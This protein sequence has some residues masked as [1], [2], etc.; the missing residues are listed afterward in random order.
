MRTDDYYSKSRIYLCITIC[1]T[2]YFVFLSM[3]CTEFLS[4]RKYTGDTFIRNYNTSFKSVFQVNNVN[5]VAE[6]TDSI[7][8]GSI[9]YNPEEAYLDWSSIEAE[10]ERIRLES[11]KLKDKLEEEK[12]KPT[13]PIHS[14][15]TVKV[16][17]SMDLPNISDTS[18][19]GYMCMH[20]V[21][22]TDSYQWK[23]LHSGDFK[24]HTDENGIMMYEDYYVV[25]M[26]SYYT[27]YKVGS[28][29]RITLDSG[30][31]FDVITGDEKADADTDSNR[32]YRPKSNGRGE[33]VEF[34]IACGSEGEV[35][36][37]YNTMTS[38]H[39]ALGNLSSLGFQGNVVKVEK[40]DD[41][42][43]TN[44]LYS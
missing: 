5:N 35:C 14:A 34:I 30:V 16:E 31:V 22:A 4:V 25:A 15:S 19:K 9:Q 32:M 40:L 17:G 3:S 44:R 24:F 1:V 26:A 7:S 6:G 29:F 37:N 8:L 10:R 20:T 39:R 21:T 27:N 36:N 41:Y 43:V 38:E 23:F 18:F 42:S 33:I 12:N 11:K 28:T 13:T 2:I